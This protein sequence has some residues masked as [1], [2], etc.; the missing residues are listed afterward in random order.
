MPGGSLTPQFKILLWGSVLF[1]WLIGVL[2][3]KPV[4]VLQRLPLSKTHLSLALLGLFSFPA[5]LLWS[6]GA[7]T[8]HILQPTWG[9]PWWIMVHLML[10]QS[11]ILPTTLRRNGMLRRTLVI[12]MVEVLQLATL[13]A[14]IIGS[15]LASMCATGLSLLVAAIAFLWTRHEIGSMRS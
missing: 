12:M 15:A 7:I 4:G 9:V 8:V 11:L 13:V 1:A 14:L 5:L 2:P 6:I 3:M 10:L